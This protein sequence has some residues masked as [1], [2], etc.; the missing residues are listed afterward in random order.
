MTAIARDCGPAGYRRDTAA[1]NVAGTV[2]AGARA[3]E[4][5]AETQWLD[6]SADATGL[7]TDAL[8]GT[9]ARHLSAYHAIVADFTLAER[10]ALF[11]G[12]A[13]RFYRLDLDWENRP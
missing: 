8:F 9:V 10:R 1:W 13:D 7:S 2:D 4:A 5:L 3:D 6:G 11:G 12:N